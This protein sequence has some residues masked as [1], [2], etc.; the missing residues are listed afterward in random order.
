MPSGHVTRAR[1][2][3]RVV[4]DKRWSRD[5]LERITLTFATGRPIVID[6]LEEYLRPHEGPQQ[7]AEHHA[8]TDPEP[9]PSRPKRLKITHADLKAVGDPEH[10]PK[11]ALHAIGDHPRAHHRHH[12]ESCRM[13]MYH[14]LR[15]AGSL[16]IKVA[17]PPGGLCLELPARRMPGNHHIL[18][19][20]HRTLRVTP[21]I[22]CQRSP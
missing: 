8:D 18:L 9:N 7:H 12:S 13:R 6:K 21:N 2:M 4:A 1:G 3:V 19:F 10:C 11:C 20:H 15:K 17:V 22:P 14:E 16:N 5:R